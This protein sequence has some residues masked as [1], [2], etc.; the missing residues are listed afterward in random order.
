MSAAAKA[1]ALAKEQGQC[2]VIKTLMPVS[3]SKRELGFPLA[4]GEGEAELHEHI[5][6]LLASQ[7][8]L[9]MSDAQKVCKTHN[10]CYVKRFSSLWQMN[11]FFPTPTFT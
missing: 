1:K 8:M 5:S 10:G 6:L 3:D 7:G 9:A 2:A 11:L 4:P